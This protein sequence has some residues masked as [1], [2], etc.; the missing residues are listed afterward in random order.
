[1]ERRC[2][3]EEAGSLLQALIDFSFLPPYL[4]PSPFPHRPLH[5]GSSSRQRFLM[6][7]FGELSTTV[8]LGLGPFASKGKEGVLT[9][10]Q[11][12]VDRY[13]GERARRPPRTRMSLG[14]RS[15]RRT[16]ACPCFPSQAPRAKPS[17]AALPRAD[18]S[19]SNWRSSSP[20][21]PPLRSPQ[22]SSTSCWPPFLRP[23]ALPAFSKSKAWG[24]CP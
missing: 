13:I 1:M 10:C 24:R 18:A 22:P 3:V 2:L 19:A 7:R 17:P 4:P 20:S 6:S 11:R 9:F 12:L 23:V 21:F 5:P 14:T 8:E 16:D 15:A